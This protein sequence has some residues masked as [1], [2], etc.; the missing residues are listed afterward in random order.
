MGH[1]D[2][3]GRRIERGGPKGKQGRYHTGPGDVRVDDEGNPI[4]AIPIKLAMWVRSICVLYRRMRTRVLYMRVREHRV[5]LNLVRS[6][7]TAQVS[8]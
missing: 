1:G 7:D 2:K 3:C 8:L 4:H 6:V 5:L